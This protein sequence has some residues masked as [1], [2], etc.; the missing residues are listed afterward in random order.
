MAKKSGIDLKNNLFGLIKFVIF[1]FLIPVVAAVTIAFNKDISELKTVY[2]HS[3]EW[4][5]FTYV[6]LHLFLSDLIWLYKFGQGMVSELFKFWEPLAKVAP[7]VFPI[8]TVL[9]MG[10]YYVVVRTMHIGPNNGWWFFVIGFT[11]A[12]HMI[13]TA[14]EMYE[15]DTSSFKPHYLFE[16]SLVYILVILLMV[17]LLNVTAW[18]F[19]VVAFSQTVFDLTRNFYFLIYFKL[20]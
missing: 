12:M 7:Y 3:F 6:L 8:Y 4:G 16:M 20:F 14:K 1:L 5:V 13:M 15:A 2:H 19:S 9:T 17:Q 11:L 10:A 18:R